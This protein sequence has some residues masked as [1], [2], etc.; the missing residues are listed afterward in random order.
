MS[1]GKHLIGKEL[2]SCTL[3]QLLGYGGSSAVYLAQQQ[4]P[5]RKV[6][7]KVFLPRDNMDKKMMRDFY[8]RFLHEAEAASKL[9]HP[10]ILPIYAYG[11][12]DSLPYIV[13]PYM[14]G[15]TLSQYVAKHGPISLAEAQWF[16]EQITSALDYAHT[17][18][19]I[20]CDVKPA[21][22]LLD[23]DGR[24][25]L[26]DFGIARLTTDDAKQVPAKNSEAM[27]G[28][29]D[30]ISP[31]Q[32]LGQAIDGRSDVYSL[33][34]TL[35]FLLANRL[36]FISDT[37]IA[38]A[39]LHVHEPPPSLA[40]IRA[41]ISPALDRVVHKALAKE[42]TQR[43]QTAG[44]FSAAFAQAV[45][46]TEKAQA[47]TLSGKRAAV[48]GTYSGSG[49][50]DSQPVIVALDPLVQVKPVWASNFAKRRFIAVACLLLCLLLTVGYI[51]SLASRG[52]VHGNSP[53]VVA[54]AT[55][56]PAQVDYLSMQN[57]WPQS[58]TFFYD[59]VTRRYHVLND[60]P[61]TVAL[62][63]CNN[64]NF[65]KFLLTVTLSEVRDT[66]RNANY[67]G[68]VFRSS[69]DQSHYYLFEIVTSGGGQYAFSRFDAGVWTPIASGPAHQLVTGHGRNNI[70]TISASGDAFAF[71]LNGKRVS[72]KPAIDSAKFPLQSGEVG[73]YV[74]EQGC[75]VAF[76]HLYIVP[77]K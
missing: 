54:T 13:M 46:P 25:M 66:A 77:R 3:E 36:P 19:C 45:A 39:L 29:P 73:L 44:E 4:N 1:R 40:L 30:Y 57:E 8:R 33:G 15:G 7:I 53:Q 52:P 24:V 49:L 76:S 47:T 41:D 5:T 34:V 38:L 55:P 64:C 67:Y 26:S 74:E 14:P 35:F 59:S 65:S 42:P 51:T 61:Q 50:S 62:A 43:F 20:H 10:N 18:G 17:H 60:S 58:K 16:L 75:E 48:L 32:A 2:G 72:R 23:G 63:L 70:V 28:T 6:A 71:S 69:S 12:Q 21:N 68:V 22:I 11:E 56:D 37:S 9:D 27:M 31:E